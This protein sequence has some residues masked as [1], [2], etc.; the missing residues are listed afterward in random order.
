MSS[1]AKDDWDDHWSSYDAS[2]KRNP[3]QSYRRHLLLQLLDLPNTPDT[4]L[5]DIGAGTG[6]FIW[7]VHSSAP[8]VKLLGIEYS[9]KGVEIARAREPSAVFHQLDLLQT[10]TTLPEYWHWGTYAVCS[11]VLEHVDDPVALLKNAATFLAPGCRLVVTV[12]GGPISAFDCYIGHRQHFTT[13]SLR[14]LLEK[15]GLQVEMVTGA[16]FPFFN[17]Y[18][19]LVLARGKALITDAQGVPNLLMKAISTVFDSLMR[20]SLLRTPL[21]WQMVAIA[22]LPGTHPVKLSITH[23]LP[24]CR[25]CSP[26]KILESAESVVIELNRYCGG[27]SR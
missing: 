18:R 2:N 27:C 22:R 17:L 24:I 23:K 20:C 13:A 11:E 10:I 7:D 15:A 16:G 26:N 19:L 25:D 6:E 9:T 5:V 4:R 12:P 3:A 21:G 1:I 8:D 14:E